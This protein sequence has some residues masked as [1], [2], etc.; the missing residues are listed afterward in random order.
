VHRLVIV[1]ENNCVLGII[2]LSDILSFIV[3]KQESLGMQTLNVPIK[4]LNTS[5]VFEDDMMDTDGQK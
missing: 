4:D 3:L 2:S 1:D 5:A